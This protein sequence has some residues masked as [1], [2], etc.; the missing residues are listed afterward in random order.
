[1]KPK[2]KIEKIPTYERIDYEALAK[3]LQTGPMY[4]SPTEIDP[5]TAGAYYTAIKKHCPGFQLKCKTAYLVR[6]DGGE[7]E[8]VRMALEKIGA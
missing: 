6:E 5:Q 4:A 7:V 1:M 8:V 2:I 3:R